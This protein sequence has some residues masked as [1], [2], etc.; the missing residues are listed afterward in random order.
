MVIVFNNLSRTYWRTHTGLFWI[1]VTPWI[2]ILE[3][4]KGILLGASKALFEPL[5]DEEDD[6]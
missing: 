4:K 2:L 1:L 5:S 3:R 6:K